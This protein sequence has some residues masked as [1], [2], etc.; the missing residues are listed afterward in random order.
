M[1]ALPQWQLQFSAASCFVFSIWVTNLKVVSSRDLRQCS[2]LREINRNKPNIFCVCYF[3]KIFARTNQTE[4][5]TYPFDILKDEI[6]F[7]PSA[8]SLS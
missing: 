5:R 6:K 4:K 1:T 2:W 7:P 3:L 8:K